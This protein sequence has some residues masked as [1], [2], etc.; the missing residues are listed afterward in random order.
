MDVVFLIDYINILIKKYVD[1]I[2]KV[3]RLKSQRP[4]ATP[5]LAHPVRQAALMQKTTLNNNSY[6]FILLAVDDIIR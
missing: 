4:G 2:A 1:K 6:D 3:P 5:R